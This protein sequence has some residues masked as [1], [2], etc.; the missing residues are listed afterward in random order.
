MKTDARSKMLR[1]IGAAILITQMTLPAFS[2][3]PPALH[4]IAALPPKTAI[5]ENK[6]HTMDP[7][8]LVL[9]R[10]RVLLLEQPSS[11]PDQMT[12]LTHSL[13]AHGRW[14]D[15]N[16]DD[17]TV[18]AWSTSQHLQRVGRLCRALVDPKSPLH[19]DPGTEEALYRALDN[20]ITNRY[21]Q[22]APNNNG[23][24]HNQIG[25]P[26]TMRD[27]LVLLG[28]RVQ[29]ERLTGALQILHQHGEMTPGNAANS[30]W[31]AQLNMMY[32]VMTH[33]T[34]LV[35]K[36]SGMISDEIRFNN[37]AGVQT[38]YSYHA[39]GPR[40]QQFHYGGAFLGD[41]ARL[42][43]LL[44]GTPWAFPTAKMKFVA[45]CI[46]NGSQW[47]TRGI[48]TVPSTLDRAIARPGTA[49]TLTSGDLR[50]AAQQLSE[51]LPDRALAL[52]A[53][54]ARQND[55]AEPLIGFHAFPCSDFTT[56]HRPAFSFF[57]KTVSDRTFSAEA[58]NGENLKGHLLT[59]GDSYIVRDGTEYAGLMPVWDWDLLPG[60]TWARDA[61]DIQRQSFVGAV[62]DAT[63]GATAMD[64]RWL[65]KTGQ[66]LSGRR[67]WASHGDIT[68]ALIGDLSGT[69]LSEPVRTAL[70][71]CRLR[72]PITVC[73]LRGTVHVLAEG[74]QDSLAV[75]WLYHAGF[76]YIPIGAQSITMRSGPVTGNWRSINSS[77]A[78]APVTLPVFLPILEQGQNPQGQASGFVVIPCA[79]P[80]QA[81]SLAAKPGWEV[82]RNDAKC[83]AVQFADGTLLTAFYEAGELRKDGHALVRVD[84][85]CLFLSTHGKASASD[86]TQQGEPVGIK[87]G[88]GP[89]MQV[90]L[91]PGG[92]TAGIINHR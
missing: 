83:Q 68:V 90:M 3:E 34:A 8:E 11:P 63:S 87:V 91:P 84:K 54:I 6:T 31:I 39:H 86:P 30:V 89:V 55:R 62:G 18:A 13:D 16:Y 22:K 51:M 15:I 20:W 26:S 21:Q 2:T 53:L 45:D 29:G 4:S 71:Q 79:A 19:N 12:A 57:V 40:L 24:W 42:G 76:V 59:C 10:S 38:D 81:A 14:P 61:G 33:D 28:S 27:I 72:G 73:D 66:T 67:F 5:P 9:D 85:P 48:H 88:D 23:W 47:M 64:M 43:W 56:Y 92:F 1:C 65:G 60:V 70:D 52:A 32:G 77:A 69:G 7:F 78:A 25:V 82:L 58:I 44:H 46:L 17:L 80:E 35:K 36:Q 50:V 75:R 37:L 41:A 49:G 74:T